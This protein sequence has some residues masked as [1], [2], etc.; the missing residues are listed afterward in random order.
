M[1]SIFYGFGTAGAG[2]A[3]TYYCDDVMFVSSTPPTLAQIDLPI[4][5]DDGTNVDYSV[6]DFG[7]NSSAVVVDPTNA[8]NMVLKSEKTSA[9]QTWA[10]TTL[11]TPMGLA[12]AIPFASGSTTI[13]VAIWSPDAGTVVRLKAEDHTNNTITVETEATTTVAA[14]WD[15]LVFDFNNPAAGTSPINFANTYDLL[16]IFYDFGIAPSTPAKTYYT[17]DVFFGG[18]SGGGPTT[19]NVTFKVDLSDY[20]V[21]TYSQVNLN[22]TFNNWC[23]S[24]AVMTSPNNDSIFEITVNVPT[25]TIEY[26][27]TLD[28][29]AIDEQLTQGSICTKTTTDPT[30]TFTNRYLVPTADTTLPAVC[31]EACIECTDIGID[32]NWVEGFKVYPNPNNGEFKISGSLKLTS[33]VSIVITDL[34]GRVVLEDAVNGNVLDKSINLENVSKGIYLV[35]IT[36][37]SGS[38]TEKISVSK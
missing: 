31:W 36:S 6:S 11:S 30:G 23:G 28:G 4:T 32:E 9:A 5:W 10:G 18:T 25:D 37:N 8:S 7:G 35:K 19:A 33:E 34:Q 29:W 15:T 38:I 24:C 16:S 20:T 17:D 2:T 21:N 22:G 12:T 26:K 13:S 27:F 1:L 14:A 3:K